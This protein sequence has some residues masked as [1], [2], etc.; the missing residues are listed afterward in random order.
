MKVMIFSGEYQYQY[1]Y[2]CQYQYQ[3]LYQYQ[4]QYKTYDIVTFRGGDGG[5][6]PTAAGG[7]AARREGPVSGL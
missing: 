5:L 3:L 1:Q 7:D 2:Q 4:Y 6:G